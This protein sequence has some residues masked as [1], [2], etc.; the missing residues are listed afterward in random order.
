MKFQ[1]GV[2][3]PVVELASLASLVPLR[4]PLPIRAS[5]FSTPLVLARAT[6]ASSSISTPFLQLPLKRSIVHPL[7]PIYIYIYLHVQEAFK[8][9]S[10]TLTRLEITQQRS[11]TKKKEETK[12]KEES[13]AR[14][15]KA[16]RKTWHPIV[17]TNYR[18]SR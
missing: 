4:V 12:R 9:R 10:W 3:K 15:R 13:R 18:V 17:V 14:A 5:S 8:K 11:E 16:L 7:L 6:T 2:T 1:V